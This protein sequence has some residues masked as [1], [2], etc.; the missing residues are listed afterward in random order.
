MTEI[1]SLLKPNPSLISVVIPVYNGE[2]YLVEAIQ[3]VLD[4]AY[5]PLEIIV[6]DDGST[7]RSPEVVAGFPQVHLVSQPQ[8]GPGAARNTGIL[9]ATGNWLAFLDADD[10]WTQHKLRLQLSAF[11]QDPDLDAVF[12]HVQQFVSP[13]LSDE[14]KNRLKCPPDPMP[15]FLPGTML[16]K[17][18]SFFRVG[19][20]N[21]V[22][23]LGDFIDW[24]SRAT[25]AGLKMLMLNDVVMRRRL[26]TTNLTLRE[27]DS[28]SDYVKMLKGVL[29]RRRVQ[30]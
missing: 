11:E 18:E 17:R 10:V 6:V 7:D 29:D 30:M 14:V 25:D 24:H 22:Q 13:E 12:G 4:Q 2:G 21:P 3:S 8:A 23:K 27:R 1:P 20:L 16:I 9:A 26:H 15:G 19:L 28:R 5:Q